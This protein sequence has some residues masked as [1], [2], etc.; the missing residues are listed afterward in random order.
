MAA[1]SNYEA[2]FT[3]DA[4]F[5]DIYRDVPNHQDVEV[6][7]G[8]R[9]GANKD[10][11]FSPAAD[12]KIGQKLPLGETFLKNLTVTNLAC[13]SDGNANTWSL[14]IWAWNTDYETTVAGTPLYVLTGEN[15]TDCAD[16]V[17]EIPAKLLISGDVY[18]EL[19]YLT[20]AGG[21]TGWTAENVYDGV[22]TYSGGVKKDGSYAAKVVVGVELPPVETIFYDGTNGTTDIPVQGLKY[23][24]RGAAGMTLKIEGAYNFV[25]TAD[26]L[27]GQ[28]VVLQPNMFGE[29]EVEVPAD[30]FSFE[31]S[32][33]NVCGEPAY[34]CMT[35]TD[36][37]AAETTNLVVGEN[38]VNAT[39]QTSGWNDVSV[40]TFTAEE[41]GDYTFT[42]TNDY[43]TGSLYY[44]EAPVYGMCDDNTV[45]LTLEAGQ[46]VEIGVSADVIMSDL[47]GA[48]EDIVYGLGLNVTKA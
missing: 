5:A 24:V 26:N 41:A 27:M 18:Y 12:K 10:I 21:F 7:L 13:Y 17:A 20:G 29:I 47:I 9:T 30:W 1:F 19:E 46:T 22:E 32:I 3:Y 15:H 2:I 14:K 48:T 34:F 31:L 25:V 6:S 4:Q 44:F 43:A 35:L 28:S 42:L 37:A 8:D 38:L 40:Y 23:F 33:E 39:V 36:P 16:F 45:T 11:P